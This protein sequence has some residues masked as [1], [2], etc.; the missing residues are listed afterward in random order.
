VG[1]FA[2]EE[3]KTATN[4]EITLDAVTAGHKAV[5]VLAGRSGG[6]SPSITQTGGNSWARPA[7]VPSFEIASG[8]NRRTVDV[9]WIEFAG[10]ESTSVEAT[11]STGT[12]YFC[13][14]RFS[15]VEGTGLLDSDDWDNGETSSATSGDTGD[16]GSHGGNT[17]AIVGGIIKKSATGESVSW[18]NYN[19][20]TQVHDPGGA[21]DM[22]I[23]MAA[24]SFTTTGTRGDTFTVGGSN[25]G[26]NGFVL[27]F[28]R[29]AGGGGD[30][31]TYRQPYQN[32]QIQ[33]M[34][35]R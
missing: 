8:T 5:A 30:V 7:N 29:D 11:L 23:A 21:F 25:D 17:V 16:T 18:D 24:E 32:R 13:V 14:W 33:H 28:D 15:G 3:F 27:L 31:A 6:G 9:W 22:E 19:D 35:I 2:S 12:E 26:L 1:T 4:G 34:V 10:T 20:S